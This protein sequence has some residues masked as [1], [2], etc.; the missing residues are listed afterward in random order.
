MSE[1]KLIIGN[2]NYSSWSMRGWLA[3][4][5]TG[6]SFELVRI[7]LDT[8][9]FE[10]RIGDYS[11]TRRVPVLHHE[12]LIV[13]DTLA[14]CEYLA[15]RFPDAGLWPNNQRLRTL[16]RSVCAE[17][18]S[19]F[20]ALRNALPLNARARGRHVELDQETVGD[21]QRISAIWHDCREA[22][23]SQAQH[24]PWL[25]GEFTAADCFYV[26]VALRFVTYA[27]GLVGFA[28]KYVATVAA[29]ALVL[30]W[31]EMAAAETESIPREE[32]GQ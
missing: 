1:T 2:V 16:A 26:P 25:F 29:D 17:M 5:R 20:P 8:P 15:E 12:G 14:M 27:I 24:G 28:S 18:H 3:A 6:M 31:C 7:P 19:G 23:G 9:E 4:K 22:A 21:I 32:V 11:P 13:W 10:E 30:E